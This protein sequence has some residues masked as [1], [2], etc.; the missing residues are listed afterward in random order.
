[1]VLRQC[2]HLLVAGE[3]RQAS[4]PHGCH[5]VLH[6]VR[7][8][9]FCSPKRVAG[10]GLVWKANDV[11]FNVELDGPVD[12]RGTNLLEPPSVRA[13]VASCREGMRPRGGCLGHLR[14][15]S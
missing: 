14:A 3:I 2:V 1:M 8:H 10:P 5:D 6:L 12:G 9:P 11:V 7:V 4:H 15:A 13:P